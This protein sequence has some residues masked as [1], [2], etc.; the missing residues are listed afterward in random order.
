MQKYLNSFTIANYL[1]DSNGNPN[2]NSELLKLISQSP[3][4]ALSAP[5]GS[6]KSLFIPFLLSKL[7][8]NVFVVASKTSITKALYDT[9]SIIFAEDKDQVAYT[10][11]YRAFGR[12][13]RLENGF[14]FYCTTTY[15]LDR[16][17]RHVTNPFHN[18]EGKIDFIILDDITDLN[19]PIIE[20]LWNFYFNNKNRIYQILGKGPEAPREGSF[21][22]KALSPSAPIYVSKLIITSATLDLDYY[23]RLG[24]PTV[25]ISP[26]SPYQTALYF[27][28]KDYHPSQFQVYKDL[29]PK[30]IEFYNSSQRGTYLVFCAGKAE[31]E[32]IAKK[33]E[34]ANLENVLIIEAYAA[35]ARD[36]MMMIEAPFEGF[37]IIIATNVF[38]SSITLDIDG[39][40]DT[41]IAKNVKLL[42]NDSIRL[43]PENISK[44]Q[45]IQRRGRV[46]R[47]KDGFYYMMMTSGK[48]QNLPLKLEP[49]IYN[50]P[51]YNVIIKLLTAG[52]NM[53]DIIPQDLMPRFESSR[54]LLTQ[55]EMLEYAPSQDL[56]SQDL[57]EN[58]NEN[59]SS[60][61]W[62]ITPVGEFAAIFNINVRL[63][64]FL[65]Y[66]NKDNSEY[67]F[68]AVI[69]AALIDTYDRSLLFVPYI[70]EGETKQDYY[71]RRKEHADA[72]FRKYQA[73][74]D[75]AV[76]LKII[77]DLM[78]SVKQP[79]DLKNE[80]E[81]KSWASGNSINFKKLK[82]IIKQINYLILIYTNAGLKM[83]AVTLDVNDIDQI[84][85]I[86]SHYL[87]F[88]YLNRVKVL[89][90]KSEN[91]LQYR[92]P[93]DRE[94]FYVL[95]QPASQ[96][97]ALAPLWLI[98]LADFSRSIDGKVLNH[99]TFSVPALFDPALVAAERLPGGLYTDLILPPPEIESGVKE[100]EELSMDEVAQM[101]GLSSVLNT[102]VDEVIIEPEKVIES[103][104]KFT[105]VGAVTREKQQEKVQQ[106]MKV[107]GGG[108]GQVISAESFVLVP[109]AQPV[110][111][112]ITDLLKRLES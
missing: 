104:V 63:A 89:H 5:T 58:L 105:T 50:M 112:M 47:I 79:L 24:V 69:I 78:A 19:G 72:Y 83:E 62:K 82:Q 57:T 40:F 95:P 97:V 11:N 99:I 8:Y 32:Y 70:N 36:A 80:K 51:L 85:S 103:G 54:L 87:E 34:D 65:F 27:H 39:V 35:V 75:L 46:G 76:Y 110:D 21:L 30:I 9:Y 7:G 71:K 48:Y 101:L 60:S 14:V 66:W 10:N 44:E 100:A 16:L 77:F 18:T 68:I 15:M 52:I 49:A 81:V 43:V 13:E 107:T 23:N 31:I 64:N 45:S 108:V 4:L 17:L 37:K 55:L 96:I 22:P 1:L 111:S 90:K 2:P 67:N 6:G 59:N 28:D 88:A 73:S 94:L 102:N 53:A 93:I 61:P 98:D 106:V 109:K 56:S 74:N 29:V 86:A 33:L 91:Y 84:V 12:K 20:Y 3:A 38:E 42:S 26:V 25:N 41:M 92:S